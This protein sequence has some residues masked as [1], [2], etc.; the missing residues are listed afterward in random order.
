M[1]TKKSQI[2]PKNRAG[3]TGTNTAM[4]MARRGH[5]RGKIIIVPLKTYDGLGLSLV[6]GL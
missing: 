5:K 1:L 3:T 2:C 6:V 4:E